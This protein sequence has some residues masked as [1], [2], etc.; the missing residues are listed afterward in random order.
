MQGH[1]V[2]DII[3]DRHSDEV[4]Q[5]IGMLRTSSQL[6]RWALTD[7]DL[8]A[9]WIE[10]S[11]TKLK[12]ISCWREEVRLATKLCFSRNVTQLVSRAE[13]GWFPARKCA[14]VKRIGARSH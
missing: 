3:L 6:S 5:I 13:P 2:T 1:D 8:T 12:E 7:S 14:R 9:R 11:E 4:F 10:N